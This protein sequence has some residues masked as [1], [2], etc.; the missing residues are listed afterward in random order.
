LL[1]RQKLSHRIKAVVRFMFLLDKAILT[2]KLP[3][4]VRKKKLLLMHLKS[5]A[6]RIRFSAKESGKW[7]DMNPGAYLM[8]AMSMSPDIGAEMRFRCAQMIF[9]P[10]LQ[11]CDTTQVKILVNCF[12]SLDISLFEKLGFHI[13]VEKCLGRSVEPVCLLERLPGT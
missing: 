3:N 6:P 5:V 13:H 12:G 4:G 8:Q 11:W 9:S 7:L 2:A 1:D 10:I